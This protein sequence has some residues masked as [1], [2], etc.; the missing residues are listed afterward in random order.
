MTFTEY[1]DKVRACWLGKNIGGTLGCP[2][3]GRRDVFDLDF[4]VHDISQGALPN[5]DLDLQLV[6]LLAAEAHG[7]MVNSEILSEFWLTY[8]PCDWSE[9]GAG[10]NNMRFGLLPPVTG[11]YRN[12]YRN[13]NGC[14]IRSEIWACLAPGDPR[15]AVRYA[16]EDAT[17]DHADEG[18][19]GELFCAAMQSAAFSIPSGAPCTKDDIMNLI[20]TGLAFIPNDCRTAQCVRLAIDFYEAG[21]TWQEARKAIL[22]AA[23][24]TFGLRYVYDNELPDKHPEPDIPMGETGYDAPSNIGIVAIGL[25]WGEGD[26]TRSLCTAA[27]CG[28]DTDCTAGTIGALLG[29]IRGCEGIEEK[30]TAPIGDHI[31][32]ATLDLTKGGI[33]GTVTELTHRIT[34]LMPTFMRDCISFDSQ[35]ILN[36]NPPCVPIEQLTR[37]K[38]GLFEYTDTRKDLTTSP[39]TIRRSN[40]LFEVGVSF[41]DITIRAGEPKNVTVSFSN[42]FFTQ[43]WAKLTWHLPDGWTITGGSERYMCVD[44]YTGQTSRTA[45]TFEIHADTLDRQRYDFVLE[46]S[47]Q[48]RPSKMF[49]PI[50]FMQA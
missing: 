31:K 2:L 44:Q 36:V 22:K 24:S 13:S 12:P 27:N 50:V 7:Q 23:P 41:A 34:R 29:I 35:G 20:R 28:E 49:I 38:C 37:I 4:Y 17:T 30:W 43:Q 15:T 45:Q 46:I 14:F 18:V 48:G 9:Y 5:D 40:A 10:K 16:F 47:A 25:L 3:E 26:F 1:A 39:L 33:P 8:I 19:Y 6:W 42:R 32:T 11:S 21:K